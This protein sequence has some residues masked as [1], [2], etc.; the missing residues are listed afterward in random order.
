MAFVFRADRTN[1]G[2]WWCLPFRYFPFKPASIYDI[3]GNM[4][5]IESERMVIVGGGGL[6]TDFFR[7]RLNKLKMPGR[8]YKL[9]AW[10]VGVDEISDRARILDAD[11][12][13][14]LFGDWY[15]DFD[16]V[17]IRC[18]GENQKY[19]WVPCASCM[20]PE[21]SEFRE[22]KAVAPVGVYHHKNV[23]LV[24]EHRGNPLPVSNNAGDNLI[25]KLEFISRHEFIVTNTYHGVYWATLLNRK[26]ICAPYKS[27]LFSFRHKPVYVRNLNIGGDVFSAARSYPDSLEECRAAN[28]GYYRYLID[29]Y[30]DL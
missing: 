16:D 27:G 19:K 26:V 4:Q 20:A 5:G 10:G 11:T 17:G 9:V 24:I 23:P 6:G 2:D 1:V 7:P 28:N 25:E 18:F 3:V 8:K 22:R 13:Y 29:K 12:R 14:D 15:A 30:G 21:L